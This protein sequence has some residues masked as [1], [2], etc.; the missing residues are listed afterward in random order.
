MKAPRNKFK[1]IIIFFGRNMNLYAW[2]GYFT[3]RKLKA[4]IT[5]LYFG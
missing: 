4:P 5:K 1:T 3:V 2:K